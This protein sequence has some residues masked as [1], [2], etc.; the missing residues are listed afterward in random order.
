MLE[1]DRV[2]LYLLALVFFGS[3]ARSSPY[4]RWLVRGLATA[5]VAIC[6]AALITR[7]LP[8]VWS[9]P[10]GIQN[11][12]LSYPIG[13]WNALGLVASLALVLC[14]H[15]TSS[16]RE[17]RVVRILAAAV[18]PILGATL[19][20]TFSR[21][22][23]VV[24]AVGIVVYMVVGRPRLL[25]T[26]FLAAA[27]ATAAAV[28]VAYQADLLAE[29]VKGR[30]YRFT[31][32]AVDQGHDVALAVGLCVVGAALVRGLGIAALDP[33]LAHLRL[34]RRT[35]RR[36]AAAGAALVLTAAVI[37]TVAATRDGWIQRQYDRLVSDPVTQTRRLPGP[38]LQPRPQPD[39]PV[40][41]RP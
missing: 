5:L 25:L 32:A 21:G 23:M 19:L 30:G 26:G 22:P 14:L 10:A 9:A 28:I 29:F 15:L 1:F 20:F 16:A 27:P 36:L 31:S 12:R 41:G 8:D 35:R 7:T 18:C 3:F 38:A 4:G 24:A 2:L 39:G 40:A 13:Y 11:N 17:S 37:G 33:H 6:T 34:R